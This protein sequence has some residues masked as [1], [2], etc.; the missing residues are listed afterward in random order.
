MKIVG[1][2]GS[3]S[4]PSRSAALL[5]LAAQGLTLQGLDTQR[6]AVRELPA[7][8]LQRAEFGHPQIVAVLQALAEAEVLIIATP[9]YKAAY[10]GLL[11]TLL[12]LLPEDGL[13]GKTV[14]PLA[15]GGS[16]AHLLALDYG[17]K[18]VLSALGARDILDGVYAVD[19]QMP[20]D[21]QGQYRADEAL[22]QRLE[23]ALQ[24]L[25]RRAAERRR[26]L[27]ATA[28]APAQLRWSV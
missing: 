25:L 27:P 12:D 7:Q 10:S 6:I 26:L 14:L 21:A 17:L 22:R 20:R 18:P 8:A 3:P 4:A 19:S 9:I 16:P 2:S 15:S 1:I 28:W 11:K 23:R 13:R 24:P 5:E